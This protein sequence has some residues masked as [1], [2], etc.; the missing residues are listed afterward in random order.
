MASVLLTRGTTLL[1]RRLLIS[2]VEPI[3]VLFDL[4]K[5]NSLKERELDCLHAFLEG[6]RLLQAVPRIRI[7]VTWSDRRT[8]AVGKSPRVV[9][10]KTA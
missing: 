1:R 6:T 8:D 5:W 10:P 7:H 9:P 3:Q 4:G 2:P